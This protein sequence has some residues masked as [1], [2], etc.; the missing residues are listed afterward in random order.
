MLLYRLIL[1]VSVISAICNTS[2]ASALVWETK[3]IIV[4]PSYNETSTAQ[5]FFFKNR[6]DTN[7]KI[8]EIKTLCGCTTTAIQ[9]VEF[10]PGE[11]FFIPVEYKFGKAT[12]FKEK[13]IIVVTDEDPP[14]S[15]ILKLKTYIP[16]IAIISPVELV[17]HIGEKRRAKTAHLT[18]AIPPKAYVIEA[19]STNDAFN[20]ILSTVKSGS[21]Y[22]V[23]VTP[24]YLDTETRGTI[25]V[26]LKIDGVTAEK[27]QKINTKIEPAMVS[28]TIAK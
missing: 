17:W 28:N 7:V 9:K 8:T 4:H 12:G 27:I 10:K 2:F 11:Q 3:E 25:E 14:A 6:G 13:E 18:M 1:L 26:T 16:T 19:M 5:Q 22:L 24:R 20:V 15:Y 21:E 23:K